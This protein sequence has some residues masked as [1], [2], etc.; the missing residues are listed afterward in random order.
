MQ[1]IKVIPNPNP[2]TKPDENKLGFGNYWY[3]GL[4]L[5]I[6]CL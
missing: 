4:F 6:I 1:E 3:L 5:Q 2:Q